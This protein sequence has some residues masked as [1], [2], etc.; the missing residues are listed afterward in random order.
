MLLQNLHQFASRVCALCPCILGQ[1]ES[2]TCWPQC[3]PDSTSTYRRASAFP[4]LPAAPRVPRHLR[5]QRPP[6]GGH[7]QGPLLPAARGGSALPPQGSN[8][9]TSSGTSHEHDADVSERAS[10]SSGL[11]VPRQG[12]WGHPHHPLQREIGSIPAVRASNLASQR[13]LTATMRSTA[14]AS[15]NPILPDGIWENGIWQDATV[16]SLP[17]LTAPGGSLILQQWVC[18]R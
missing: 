7:R 15:L 17:Q 11:S 14:L 4:L 18:L 5:H 13:S 2:S 16:Q 3:L 12:H 6:Q 10:Q 9:I 8:N 1:T